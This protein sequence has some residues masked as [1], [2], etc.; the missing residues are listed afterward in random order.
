LAPIN[1]V[2]TWRRSPNPVST[3]VGAAAPGV[4]HQHRRPIFTDPLLTFCEHLIGEVCT[5]VGAA[6]REF[7]GETDHMHLLVHYPP[8]LALSVL[9]KRRDGVSSRGLRQQYP[10]HIGKYL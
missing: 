5:G 10:V 9:V 6:L 7:T 4:R 3:C 8:S 2:T 1:T